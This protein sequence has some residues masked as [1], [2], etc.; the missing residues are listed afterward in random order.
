MVVGFAHL[1]FEVCP[2]CLTSLQ[3]GSS[4]FQIEIDNPIKAHYNK[5]TSAQWM[6]LF[7]DS[8]TIELVSFPSGSNQTCTPS[9]ALVVDALKVTGPLAPWPQALTQEEFLILRSRLGKTI[10]NVGNDVYRVSGLIG[11]PGLEIRLMRNSRI[12]A[13]GI[14]RAKSIGVYVAQTTRLDDMGDTSSTIVGG[15]RFEV[16]FERFGGM[17]LEYIKKL[18]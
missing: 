5:T 4:L 9:E 17:A 2:S 11:R 8:Q 3:S 15:Q 14:H 13:K 1:T 10:K 12:D 16:L 7:G 18:D 6:R